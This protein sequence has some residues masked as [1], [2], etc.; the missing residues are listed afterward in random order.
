M[1]TSASA[2][3]QNKR[4]GATLCAG[5]GVALDAQEVLAMSNNKSGKPRNDLAGSLEHRGGKKLSQHGTEFF[6]KIHEARKRPTP[7]FRGKK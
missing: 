7:G 5:S 1:L 2:E 4:S 6:H 3:S